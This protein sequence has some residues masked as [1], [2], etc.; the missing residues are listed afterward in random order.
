[1]RR[2]FALVA[3]AG[4][5]WHDLGSPQSPPP[6][7]RQLSCLTLSSSQDYRHAPPCLADFCIFSR[8][9]VSPCWPGW[10]R[11]PDLKRS[12]LPQPHSRHER[13]HLAPVMFFIAEIFLPYPGASLRLQIPFG[14]NISSLLQSGA[15][16]HL[17]F[18][19]HDTN[20]FEE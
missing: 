1:M 19:F 3:Q 9:G 2:S 4:V 11:T 5:Q 8:D 13:P 18:N 14:Y 12:A 15:V 6:G 10:S 17:P 20:I 7:F 16:P